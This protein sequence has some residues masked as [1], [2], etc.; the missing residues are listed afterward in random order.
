V[1]VCPR[2]L[3]P[4]A[5]FRFEPVSGRG[6]IRTWTVMHTAFLP[7]F[8]PEVPWVIVQAE[9]DE[10]DGLRY[11]AALVDGPTAGF[12][13][14]SPVEVVFEPLAGGLVLPQFRL[15]GETP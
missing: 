14:G 5:S 13:I 6:V 4:K 8:A 9:L 11:L 2:C 15:V 3:D 1:F 10:Q 7:A 12:G